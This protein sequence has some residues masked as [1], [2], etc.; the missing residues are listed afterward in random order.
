MGC[1]L[2]TRCSI[3]RSGMVCCYWVDC[4]WIVACDQEFLGCE[5]TPRPE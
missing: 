1:W 4:C 5:F 3:A 2:D